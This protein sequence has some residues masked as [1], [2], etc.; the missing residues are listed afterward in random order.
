MVP[1]RL[2]SLCI[3]LKNA[4]GN[5]QVLFKQASI[6]VKEHTVS[7]TLFLEIRACAI[8]LIGVH[9]SFLPLKFICIFLFAEYLELYLSLWTF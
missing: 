3:S 7:G 6:Y 5:L 8:Q 1:H 2:W 4:I 9:K